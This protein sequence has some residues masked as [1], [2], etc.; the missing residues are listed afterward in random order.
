MM[1]KSE[2]PVGGTGDR[3]LDTIEMVV[4]WQDLGQL[5]KKRFGGDA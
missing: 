2:Q 1:G 5:W 3:K 4:R